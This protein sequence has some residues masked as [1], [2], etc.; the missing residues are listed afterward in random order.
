MDTLRQ[1]SV[2]GFRVLSPPGPGR[3]GERRPVRLRSVARV[4]QVKPRWPENVFGAIGHA[5][6]IARDLLLALWVITTL[7]FWLVVIAGGVL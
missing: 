4:G 6:R 2:V 5:L 7:A 3:I 1:V